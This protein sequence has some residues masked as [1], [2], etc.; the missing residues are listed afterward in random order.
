MAKTLLKTIIIKSFRALK[1][2]EVSFGKDITVLC[3][4][5]GT[6]KSS[7]LGI[8]AQIFSFDKD[9][10][11]D[12]KLSF[13]TITD[14]SFKSQFSD[15]FRVSPKFDVT[16]SM[17]IVVQVYDAYTS[18]DAAGEL[19]ITTR[20]SKSGKTPRAV[21]RNNSSVEEGSNKDR[22]FTHPVIY[23]SLKRLYPIAHR[24][25]YIENTFPYLDIPDNA[26]RFVNLT[27]ELLGKQ[28]GNFTGTTGC[29][30]QG[31]VL[32]FDIQSCL[33]TLNHD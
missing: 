22:N 28:V 31:R 23:L 25:K 15:H 27:N 7:I 3:G 32:T 14:E 8:A 30:R 11:N 29:P 16:G 5:N 2:V 13:K 1:N 6:A 33:L 17:D 26:R 24:E 21:F 20:D 10:T 19:T 18:S 12:K 4:K 9:Y